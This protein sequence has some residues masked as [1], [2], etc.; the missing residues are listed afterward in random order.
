MSP[1]DLLKQLHVALQTE[2]R[3]R[4]RHGRRMVGLLHWTVASELYSDWVGRFY[5]RLQDRVSGD[6][7]GRPGFSPRQPP[8]CSRSHATCLARIPKA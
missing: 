8:V 1:V 7:Q 3:F 6:R 2:H 4:C 5:G